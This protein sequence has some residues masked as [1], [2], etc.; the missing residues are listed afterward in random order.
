MKASSPNPSVRAGMRIVVSSSVASREMRSPR[1][2]AVELKMSGLALWDAPR[3]PRA[4]GRKVTRH[5]ISRRE[6]RWRTRIF[7]NG[8]PLRITQH[9][10]HATAY[11]RV[12]RPW[13]GS[14]Q[15]D[16]TL[17]G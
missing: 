15:D 2:S 7:L 14:L 3:T 11:Y 6:R 17:T 4:G 16:R 13:S 12:K 1:F 9:G 10:F 5:D 8:A